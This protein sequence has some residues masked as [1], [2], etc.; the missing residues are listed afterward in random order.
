MR[1][2]TRHGEGLD[3]AIMTVNKNGDL[4]VLFETDEEVSR[5]FSGPSLAPQPKV[6]ETHPDTRKKNELPKETAR[7]LF[8]PA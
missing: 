3:D 7:P 6:G 1:F 4:R 8:I 2:E 5:K